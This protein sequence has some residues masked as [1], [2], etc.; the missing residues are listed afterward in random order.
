MAEG[1]SF[2]NK[3]ITASK[4]PTS[5]LNTNT[6]YPEAGGPKLPGVDPSTKTGIQNVL[7]QYQIPFEPAVSKSPVKKVTAPPKPAP[8]PVAYDPNIGIRKGETPGQYQA[9]MVGAKPVANIYPSSSNL[10][11]NY[12]PKISMGRR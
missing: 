11:G 7:P 4:V 1:G 12:T 8:K 10:Y 2:L 6:L 9:R 3:A 5:A